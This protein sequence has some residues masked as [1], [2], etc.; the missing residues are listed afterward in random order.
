MH[1]G[2]ARAFSSLSTLSSGVQRMEALV[3]FYMYLHACVP[4]RA[5]SKNDEVPPSAKC[6]PLRRTL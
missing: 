3:T 6:T 2:V 4:F 1:E 5:S